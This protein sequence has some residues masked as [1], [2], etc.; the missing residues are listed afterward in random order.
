MEFI[1][2]MTAKRRNCAVGISYKDSNLCFCSENTSSSLHMECTLTTTVR[3]DIVII[4]WNI[5][6]W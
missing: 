3:W 5:Y 4:F 6:H 2:N 1:K